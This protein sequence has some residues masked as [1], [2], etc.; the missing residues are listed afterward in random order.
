ME[1]RLDCGLVN[2]NDTFPQV[3]VTSEDCER[4]DSNPHP[5]RDW[6]LSPARLPVPP[7]SRF[8]FQAIACVAFP[9]LVR[10]TTAA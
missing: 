10:S 5:L 8:V 3:H 7:L 9:L 4:G 6:I 2:D 1:G